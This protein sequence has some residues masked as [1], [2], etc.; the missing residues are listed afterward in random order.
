MSLGKFLH[1]RIFNPLGMHDTGFYVPPEK[2]HRFAALYLHNESFGIPTKAGGPSFTLSDDPSKSM[3]LRPP[4]LESGGGGLV[5]TIPDWLK[6]M[7]FLL[8]KGRTDTGEL[9]LSSKTF[10]Y[11][12]RNHLPGT[13]DLEIIGNKCT[14]KPNVLV[15]KAMGWTLNGF[16]TIQNETDYDA[17]CSKGEL[18]WGSVASGYLF[19]DHKEGLAVIMKTQLMPSAGYPWRRL[20]HGFVYQALE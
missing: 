10:E 3:W 6:W 18:A 17:L 13:V 19:V 5:S 15:K 1:T 8:N 20:I 9:L 4:A 2:A 12:A 7:G 11:C 16:A 14:L